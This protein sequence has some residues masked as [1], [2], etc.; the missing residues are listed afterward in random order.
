MRENQLE[1][2]NVAQQNRIKPANIELNSG[3]EVEPA[4]LAHHN[5]SI[6]QAEKNTE[7][8]NNAN[9]AHWR[10]EGGKSEINWKEN[11]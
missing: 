11:M 3:N 8:N 9:R 1:T 4:T 7:S 5:N 2:P 6:S 10:A